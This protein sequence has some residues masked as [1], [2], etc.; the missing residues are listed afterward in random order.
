MPKEIKDIE[1]FIQ[2][3]EN[4]ESCDIKKLDDGAKLKLRTPKY[5]YTLRVSQD[6]VDEVTKR[7]KCHTHEI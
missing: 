6:K 4:A 7:I 2:L 5:L 3:S 1:K